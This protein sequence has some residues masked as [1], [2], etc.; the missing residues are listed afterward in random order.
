MAVAAVVG[1]SAA[2]AR[3]GLARV[4][5]CGKDRAKVRNG[6]MAAWHWDIWWHVSGR[7]AIGPALSSVG[8]TV[9][10]QPCVVGRWF[11]SPLPRADRERRVASD[12]W[13]QTG[14]CC[15]SPDIEYHPPI[16]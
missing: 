11:H 7:V 16:G 13:W 9:I 4:S 15:I 6:W 2:V 10:R 12:G 3:I 14:L 1:G 5:T 8:S